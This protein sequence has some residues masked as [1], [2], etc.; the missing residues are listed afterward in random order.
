MDVSITAGDADALRGLRAWL[1][2]ELALRG[3]VTARQGE[4][5][6]HALMGNSADRS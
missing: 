3:R 2:D 4:A 6:R 5:G 1:S